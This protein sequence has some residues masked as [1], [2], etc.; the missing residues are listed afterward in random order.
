MRKIHFHEINIKSSLLFKSELIKH[1]L[2]VFEKE[3]VKI[4]RVDI[5]FCSDD[6]LLTL[7]TN[8][9]NHDYYTDTLS[10]ILSDV[11]KPIKG[12]VYIST[13]RVISN[14]KRFETPYQ[15]ELVRVIIHG[16]LHLC[17]YLDKPKSAATKMK[18]QQEKYLGAFLVPRET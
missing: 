6:Y 9:L 4:N 1:L 7:N 3:K 18:T 12:E 2:L 16:C 10:F 14:A 17:G 15:T 11:G 13:N 5:I 8:F